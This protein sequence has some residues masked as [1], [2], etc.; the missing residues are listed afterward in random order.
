MCSLSQ[1]ARWIPGI[2]SWNMWKSVRLIIRFSLKTIFFHFS[3]TTF[4]SFQWTKATY[5]ALPI[6]F[7]FFIFRYYLWRWT[8][9]VHLWQ[10]Q[11][12]PYAQSFV[13]GKMQK[14]DN[15]KTTWST[16]NIHQFNTFHWKT[17]QS[18]PT[19]K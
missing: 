5:A 10:S 11:F 7:F 16:C 2:V 18:S 3:R 13:R 6:F 4:D 9:L 12:T 1:L 17:T 8:L 15:Y 14:R 19:K